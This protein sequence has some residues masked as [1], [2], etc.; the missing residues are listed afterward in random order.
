[1]CNNNKLFTRTT[2]TVFIDKINLISIN[3]LALKYTFINKIWLF[4][5][6]IIIKLAPSIVA[7]F[8]DDQIRTVA[9]LLQNIL[10]YQQISWRGIIESAPLTSNGDY[11]QCCRYICWHSINRRRW[12]WITDHKVKLKKMYV[13]VCFSKTKKKSGKCITRTDLTV[14][15]TQFLLCTKESTHYHDGP[16]EY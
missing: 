4:L 2:N 7:G 15:Q 14:N 6:I 16:F 8:D 3:N 12:R 9:I 10:W 13:C 1:M 11:R 5:L